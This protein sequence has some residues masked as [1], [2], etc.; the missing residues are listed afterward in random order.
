MVKMTSVD[1]NVPVWDASN[2]GILA[3]MDTSP[4]EPA[5]VGRR[6]IPGHVPIFYPSGAVHQP[7]EK[8]SPR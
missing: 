4:S 6:A 7:M 5:W 1:N 8:P 3:W 2:P